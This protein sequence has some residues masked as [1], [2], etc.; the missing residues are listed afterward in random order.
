MI[1]GDG[2]TSEA[3]GKLKTIVH[4]Y[5]KDYSLKSFRGGKSTK[6][7]R[8][9][10]DTDEGDQSGGGRGPARYGGSAAHQLKAHGYE[11]TFDSFEDER[12][13]IWERLIQVPSRN[14]FPSQDLALTW[15]VATAPCSHCVSCDRPEQGRI[16]WKAGR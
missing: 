7:K 12:G 6:G 14:C 2:R 11:L 3:V 13:G 5:K 8:K 9:R 10:S 1:G 16:N 4:D 15:L